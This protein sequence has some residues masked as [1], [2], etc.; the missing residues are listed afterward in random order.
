MPSRLFR[1]FI[2]RP[3]LRERAR[4]ATTVVGIAL[5]VAVVIAI[6]LTN[7]S[8]VRG[9]ETALATV[10]G[11]TSIEII[12]P[13]GADETRLP[14]LGWLRE[15]GALS[16]VIE[17]EMALVSDAPRLG[18]APDR[19]DA[20]ERPRRPARR[21]EAV[22]VLGVDILRDLTLRDY[23]VAERERAIAYGSP[24][25]SLTAQQ[26]LELLTSPRS[27]VITEKLARRRG[28]ALGDEVRLMAGDR[29]NTFVIRALL[30]DEGP[31]RV[32]DGSFVLMD[33]AAAQLAFDRLGRVDRV[34]VLIGAA[35]AAADAPAID[36]ALA[37]INARLPDGLAAQ[38]PGRRGEQVE[39]MLAAFHL[40]LTAL[41]W[42]A[43]VVGLFLVYNTVTISVIARRDEIGM[44]R[45][46]GVTRRQVLALF[47]GEAAVLG[48][49]GTVVGIGL[50][51]ALAD[52][53]VGLTSSTVSTLYIATAAATPALSAWHVGVAFA[54]GVPLSLL[55]A[56]LPAREASQVP[57]TAAMRGNDRLDSRRRL[58]AS[59]LLLPAAVLAAA[60]GLAMLGPV[61]GRPLFG[62]AASF[63]TIMGASL[64]VPAII[65]G[66]ARALGGVLRRLLGVEGMLAHAN[67]AAA[68]PRLSISIA[69]LAVSLSMMVAVA[70]MIGSFRDTVA[71]WIGQTLQADLFIGPGVQPTVGSEQTL[72]ATA[73]AAV[74]A[75]PDVEVVDSFRNID[76]VYNGNLVVLG[77]GNFDIVLSHGSLLF[78]SPADGREALRRAIGTDAVVVSEA[79]ANK[80]RT[81][82]GDVLTLQTP[83][84]AHPFRV[85]AVYYD[86]AVDRGVIVMDRGTFR[87]Y[88]GDLTPTGMAAYLRPGADPERV[89]GEILESLDEGH[90]VFIYTNRDLR[91]EVLRIFDSTFA[92][93][94]ALEIIAIVVAMLGVGATLL[95]LVI[96]RRRDL[97]MLRLIGA[98]RR[99]VQ[100]VVVIEAALIGAASQA[101]GL[102]VGL[103]LSVLLVYVINVQSFGWTIQFRVPV[104]FLLQV[105]VA[106]VVATAIAGL[107]PARRAARLVVEHDE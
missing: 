47:L 3:L 72:S 46:L 107:Y 75:H 24:V 99:Q 20:G 25:E 33:I 51:R 57:P 7:Q 10:A 19:P 68:I 13:G 69:A 36:A 21:S 74:G 81:R 90:R 84:G 1:H 11:R 17:G 6:Q 16:P 104:W 9:F 35:D 79:F 48:L 97:S 41:S 77:A 106:V 58:R 83:K 56:V 18:T 5:G 88:F 105:S 71:Y 87:Q 60:G 91:A 28:Y 42:V 82:P 53:A 93:T 63:A 32:M 27:I 39:R 14:A 15:F 55:A 38:R 43:L 64:L 61:N 65:Y 34:D 73:M 95:T 49:A 70:V 29:V 31:A 8:S 76:L 103:A 96:E 102:V 30:K 86:Y 80:Y 26:F 78:K 44:L 40:N 45:A 92:I 62:Y 67:L 37:A 101:I 54:I 100:R 59:A 2:L 4:S 94:Y 85:A 50:G 89:R 98:A 66:L 52:A 22:K 12:G 23:V